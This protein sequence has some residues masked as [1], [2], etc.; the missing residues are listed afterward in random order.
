MKLF[1]NSL[2]GWQSQ[3]EHT[4]H[5]FTLQITKNKGKLL[6]TRV[7][8]YCLLYFI[9]KKHKIHTCFQSEMFL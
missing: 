2:M 3:A 7:H 1:R 9:N 5:I 6:E 4:T 8:I